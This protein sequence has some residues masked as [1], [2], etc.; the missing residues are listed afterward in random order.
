MF[1]SVSVLLLV[2]VERFGVSRMRDFFYINFLLLSLQ[3]MQCSAVQSRGSI[4][5]QY[6]AVHCKS[7]ICY[8]VKFDDSSK[9]NY[10]AL[11]LQIHFFNSE[12]KCTVKE[13]SAVYFNG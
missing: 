3:N 12:V 13:R 8:T 11:K 2:S 7:P 10:F 5:V 9:L 6:I 4:A 1:F